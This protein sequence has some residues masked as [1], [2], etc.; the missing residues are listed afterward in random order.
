MLAESGA[1]VPLHEDL[2]F[3]NVLHHAGTWRLIDPKGLLGPAAYDLANLFITPWD[4]KEIVLA[5]GRAGRLAT[6]LAGQEGHPHA[7]LVSW[8]IAHAALA[9]CWSIANGAS[10]RHPLR[11]LPCLIKEKATLQVHPCKPGPSA[12]PKA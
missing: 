10:G 9:T 4:R 1:P 3:R 8:A 7:T 11:A 2:H 12:F 6:A 5:P